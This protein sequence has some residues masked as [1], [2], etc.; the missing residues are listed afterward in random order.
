MDPDSRLILF[1]FLVKTAICVGNIAE[2]APE[3]CSVK[4]SVRVR[5]SVGIRS[6]YG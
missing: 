4:V 3:K 6:E 5:V 1:P 2:P